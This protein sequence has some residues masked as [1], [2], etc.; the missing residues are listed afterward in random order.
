ML[1]ADR[2][3][4]LHARVI[5]DDDR[6]YEVPPLNSVLAGT[7]DSIRSSE[8]PMDTFTDAWTGE[9]VSLAEVQM[10]S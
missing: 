1:P 7:V 4:A 3:R 2:A 5:A 6:T 8:M 9:A 10:D